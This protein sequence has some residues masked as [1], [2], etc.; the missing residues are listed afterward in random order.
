MGGEF[1]QQL[2]AGLGAFQQR[3]NQPRG[4]ATL[5]ATLDP[6][7]QQ[8][9]E[10]VRRGTVEAPVRQDLDFT[11]DVPVPERPSPEVTEAGVERAEFPPATGQAVLD[12]PEERAPTDEELRQ[13][14]AE[15]S[16]LEAGVFFAQPGEAVAP[17]VI[18]AQ[19]ATRQL[20][21]Q[22]AEFAA[23]TAQQQ[24]VNQFLIDAIGGADDADA[25]RGIQGVRLRTISANPVT[26]NLT[27]NLGT[28][29][30]EEQR[31]AAR[32]TLAQA[33]TAGAAQGIP[34]WKVVAQMDQDPTSGIQ[35][36]SFE[37]KRTG[38]VNI[39]RQQIAQLVQTGVPL[40]DAVQTAYL[41]TGHLPDEV[42]N[43]LPANIVNAADLAQS[44]E[45]GKLKAESSDVADIVRKLRR[46]DTNLRAQQQA[47]VDFWKPL[48]PKDKDVE[49]R[50]AGINATEQILE[51]ADQ[52][53]AALTGPLRG[54]TPLTLLETFGALKDGEALL[55]TKIALVA[56]ETRRVLL[57]TQQTEG[58][59]RR[60]LA[61]IPRETDTPRVAM[62]KFRA[63]LAHQ[64]RLLKI[65]EAVL[66]Q[67]DRRFKGDIKTKVVNIDGQP[68]TVLDVDKTLQLTDPSV[69]DEFPIELEREAGISVGKD[70][71][72]TLFNPETGETTGTIAPTE[73]VLPGQG[74]AGAAAPGTEGTLSP[75]DQEAVRAFQESMNKQ[76]GQ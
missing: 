27:F 67:A 14:V 47:M 71:T 40:G 33:I 48:K 25:G 70:G 64:A 43:L 21:Q 62:A 66:Q 17:S 24:R 55:R 11:V 54:R 57:G 63:L 3:L 50:R 49:T 59:A 18:Q 20:R 65:Q 58:E 1:G 8:V 31:G 5:P 7:V 4:R 51:I 37:D 74:T 26:G 68:T 42:K 30:T 19:T 34:A 29:S 15:L 60:I 38:L 2:A 13:R 46:E 22:E 41:N 69:D 39:A 44:K 75:E 23:K 35:A 36:L 28:P 73:A 72:I 45:E 32:T 56:Q 76:L 6:R 10:A 53:D 16:P 12:L 9:T 52:F 61:T